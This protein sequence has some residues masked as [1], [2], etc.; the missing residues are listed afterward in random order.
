M[1][2]NARAL[3]LWNKVFKSGTT[4]HITSNLLKVVFHKFYFVHSFE[5][6][7]PYLTLIL[8]KMMSSIS[9]TPNPTHS[10]NAPL[11][12]IKILESLGKTDPPKQNGNFN[13]LFSWKPICI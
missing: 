11:G 8:V 6:F 10:V 5:C 2:I 1:N 7:V 9:A 4:D 12:F 3:T 13:F